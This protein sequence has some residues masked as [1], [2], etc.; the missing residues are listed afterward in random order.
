M[1]FWDLDSIDGLDVMCSSRTHESELL[2]ACVFRE[3]LRPKKGHMLNSA[4]QQ[5]SKKAAHSA[6]EEDQRI[7]SRLRSYAEHALPV[8]GW[9]KAAA[10]CSAIDAAASGRSTS[11][12]SADIMLLYATNL[13]AT[14]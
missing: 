14:L 7:T 9:R 2:I 12:A 10:R 1:D 6:Y 8:S 3:Q 13:A 5:L 4:Y 11:K